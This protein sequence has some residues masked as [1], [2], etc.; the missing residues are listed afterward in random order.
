M[1][2]CQV[3][4]FGHRSTFGFLHLVEQ[5]SHAEQQILLCKRKFLSMFCY[6]NTFII[7]YTSYNLIIFLYQQNSV[8]ASEFRTFLFRVSELSWRVALQNHKDHCA[9]HRC[10]LCWLSLLTASLPNILTATNCLLSFSLSLSV[11][12]RMN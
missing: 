10:M 3:L 9:P 4:K 5:R 6:E 12:G 8:S 1:L 7:N 2:C 11:S